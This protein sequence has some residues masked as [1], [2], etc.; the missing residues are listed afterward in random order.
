MVLQSENFINEFF[1]F[2]F[3]LFSQTRSLALAL[4]SDAGD[5]FKQFGNFFIF[6]SNVHVGFGELSLEKDD[7]VFIVADF[8]L[9]GVDVFEGGDHLLGF[10]F[11]LFAIDVLE[12]GFEVF[13]FGFESLFF[14]FELYSEFL[15]VFGEFF[16]L[17]GVVL[18]EGIPEEFFALEVV[19]EG[20]DVL[21]ELLGVFFGD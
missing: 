10:A 5:F 8:V 16:D 6:F 2:G 1:L 3:I 15:V 9:L 20:V 21:V 19:F 4:C 18:S 11:E 7:T 13:D 12:S 14:L 17:V